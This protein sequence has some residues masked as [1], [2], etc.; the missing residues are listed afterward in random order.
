MGVTAN[1]YFIQ[2]NYVEWGHF[3]FNRPN[4]F[5]LFGSYDLP[6][7]RGKDFG[8]NMNSVADAIV[9]GFTLNASLGWGSG[10][11]Y[12]MT[13]NEAGTDDP[14]GVKKPNQTGN[15]KGTVGS[16]NPAGHYQLGFTPVAPFTTNG[17]SAGVWSRT[18]PF[19]QGNE[20]SNNIF[21]PGIFTT[22]ATLRKTVTIYE[23]TKLSVEVAARN[24][25]N[26]VNLGTPNNCIDC[27]NGGQIT[28]IVGGANSSLGG[29]RQLEFGAHVTF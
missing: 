15:F 27:N 26:H 29:M 19:T 12:N 7:G 16:F 6:F 11:P 1:T 21:G 20:Q 28:D 22:D 13:Y 23:E 10:L 4:F 25:F 18:A 5:K 9:G 8:A 24:V 3:G 14:T 17:A 2:N